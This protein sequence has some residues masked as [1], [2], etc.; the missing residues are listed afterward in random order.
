M[1]GFQAR[2][3]V[4]NLEMSAYTAL[5]QMLQWVR[6]FR[7]PQKVLKIEKLMID[8]SFAFDSFQVISA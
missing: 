5:F 3:Q 6:F 1:P 4:N 7:K 2:V 8:I